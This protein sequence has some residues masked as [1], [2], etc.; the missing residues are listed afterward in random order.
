MQNLIK[1]H[2]N[3]HS[4][5]INDNFSEI[6]LCVKKIASDIKR[7]FKNNKTIFFVGNGG[8]AADCEHLA[9]E[10][11]GRYKK[12]RKPIKAHSLSSDVGIITCIAN[13]YGFEK[14]FSR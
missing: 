11:V 4:K 2:I 1:Q 3:N 13:D 14:I 8:S 9:G 5:I 10:L 12:D 6:S 7:T